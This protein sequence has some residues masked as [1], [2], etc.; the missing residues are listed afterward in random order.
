MSDDESRKRLLFLE[1]L[2][3]TVHK[4]THGG[5]QKNVPEPDATASTANNQQKNPRANR[6]L[7]KKRHPDARLQGKAGPPAV[8]S[9]RLPEQTGRERQVILPVRHV[10]DFS[11]VGQVL[12]SLPAGRR[13]SYA[14]LIS[15]V[16]CVV[17]PII[18][19]SIY[20]FFIASNE[21]VSEFRFTVTDSNTPSAASAVS[22]L[23][24]L[25]GGSAV[26][27][28][29]QNYLV[30]DYLT[31]REAV[32]Q[33]QAK[34]N[35]KDIYSRPTID[36]WSRFN[37]SKPIEKFV[38]YWRK[39]VTADY[40]Q[41]TGLATAQVLAFSPQDAYSVA[42]ELV[43]LAEKL[44]NDIATRPQKDAVRYAENEVRRAEDRLKNIRGE[45]TKYRNMQGVIDPNSSVVV[46]N[47]TLAQ[48]LRASLIQLQT[49]LGSLV[50]QNINA[51][52]P[53]A[54]VLQSR[55]NATK[56]QLAGV[57]AQISKTTDGS[58]ALS[59]VVGEYEQLDL[60][61]QF[62][63]NMVTS[64]MQTLEQARATAAAQHLYIT[65]Y[66]RPSV[67]ESATYPKRFSSI[68][69]VAITSF[70]IWVFGLLMIRSIREHV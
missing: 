37:A 22:G 9:A 56:A 18:F 17:V 1:S 13:R 58:Q 33:L 10:P 32:D 65:P 21:Y 69:M 42:S 68:G 28:S 31:S 51:T 6:D 23:S 8:R 40:D 57:E 19:A 36:W 43:I 3:A 62:A 67:P 55:I 49:E 44:V 30:T 54:Q 15:F 12:S 39:M 46:S 14:G 11:Q 45:M 27:S 4:E 66:V 16:I 64:T 20:Y 53:T 61:R 63:Q 70:L 5:P 29:S 25:L 35:I 60:E 47:V 52:S 50:Q 41:V 7:R 34:I 48:N 2:A 59:K 26:P 24:S 38:P